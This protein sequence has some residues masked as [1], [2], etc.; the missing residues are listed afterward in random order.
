MSERPCPEF[1][2]FGGNYPDATCIDGYLWDLDSCDVPGGPLTN[3]GDDPCPFC[4]FEEAVESCMSYRGIS[5]VEA[6]KRINR[7][8][9]EY[10]FC[11]K[12][13]SVFDH[14]GCLTGDCPHDTQAECDAALASERAATPKP[15][16]R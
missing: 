12:Y 1:P 4:N 14:H 8:R 3:G 5:D 16:E 10:G 2:F 13:P 9:A 6:I 11:A 7:I 15:E